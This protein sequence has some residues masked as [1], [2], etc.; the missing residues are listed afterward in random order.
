MFF[1]FKQ[2]TA[3]EMRI[4]DWSSDMCS[5]DLFAAFQHDPVE[6]VHATERTDRPRP[7]QQTHDAAGPAQF[8]VDH[9]TADLHGTKVSDPG[10]ADAD[11]TTFLLTVQC[12]KQRRQRAERD[13][14]VQRTHIAGAPSTRAHPPPPTAA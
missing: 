8:G 9:L 7:Q 11:T 5:S 6:T 12:Q 1:F 14:L 10:H 13:R 4:S 2:K 3:Y